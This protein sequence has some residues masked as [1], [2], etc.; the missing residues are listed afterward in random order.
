LQPNIGRQRANALIG[1]WQWHWNLDE[2][3]VKINGEMHCL[4]RAVDHEGEVLESCVTRT[5]DKAAVLTFMRKALKCRGKVETIV[6]DGLRR[7]PGGRL[8]L[9]S[10]EA[11]AWWSRRKE[12]PTRQKMS[13][14]CKIRWYARSQTGVPKPGGIG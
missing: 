12:V 13:V 5:R 11:A 9:N 2:I 10:G 1:F 3:Y 8:G 7:A 14:T 6:T 4:W